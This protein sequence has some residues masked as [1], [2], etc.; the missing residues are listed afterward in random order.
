[1]L[2]GLVPSLVTLAALA[3]STHPPPPSGSRPVRL[4]VLLRGEAS[5][6]ASQPQ[7]L[8]LPDDRGQLFPLTHAAEALLTSLSSTDC[9][10][11]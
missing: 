7:C 1:M 9:A 2:K 6:S 11:N 10:R 4:A 5:A 3:L 8:R